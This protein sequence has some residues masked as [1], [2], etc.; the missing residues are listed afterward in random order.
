MM[1][2]MDK[3]KDLLVALKAVSYDDEPGLENFLRAVKETVRSVF[4]DHSRYIT[5]LES[6]RF[7]SASVFTSPEHSVRYWASGKKQLRELLLVM[8]EDHRFQ[9]EPVLAGARGESQSEYEL[10]EAERIVSGYISG[11]ADVALLPRIRIDLRDINILDRRVEEYLTRD[12]SVRGRSATVRILCFSG[13]D[14]AL[15][16]EVMGFLRAVDAELIC[17]PYSFRLGRSMQEHLSEY[18]DIQMVIVIL[19]E[20]CWLSLNG[21]GEAANISSPAPAVCFSLG[22]LTGRF[23]REKVVAFYKEGPSFRRPVPP[24]YPV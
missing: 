23:G 15:N 7:H 21:K 4:C 11:A 10:D 24:G 20:D 1:D 18:A 5:F 14:E 22:H 12:A 16:R 2:S 3:I 13:Q 8:L 17:V 19:G 6:I 9:R